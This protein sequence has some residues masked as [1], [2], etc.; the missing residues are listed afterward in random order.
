MLS[1]FRDAVLKCFLLFWRSPDGIVSLEKLTLMKP[2]SPLYPKALLVS[3]SLL[4]HWKIVGNTQKVLGFSVHIYAWSFLLSACSKRTVQWL[5]SVSMPGHILITQSKYLRLWCCVSQDFGQ[6]YG[7][8]HLMWVS[9]RTFSLPK[10][11]LHSVCLFISFSSPSILGAIYL[12]ISA[13]IIA[14]AWKQPKPPVL[15]ECISQC[16]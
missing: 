16:W 9:Y 1:S 10:K 11:I 15:Y 14:R 13:F 5:Q 7:E 6:I 12:F 4:G 8:M 3:E 2:N